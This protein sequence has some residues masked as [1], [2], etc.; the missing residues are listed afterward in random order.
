[1]SILQLFPSKGKNCFPLK[2]SKKGKGKDSAR[3][4]NSED[5]SIRKK[6]GKKKKK[7]KKGEKKHNF[8]SEA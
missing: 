3:K 2:K 5:I 4:D 1:M 6:K 7:E 8:H